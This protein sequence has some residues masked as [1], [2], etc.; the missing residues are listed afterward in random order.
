VVHALIIDM[1][2]NFIQLPRNLGISPQNSTFL[3]NKEKVIYIFDTPHLIKATRN[4]LLKYNF[5]INNK[6]AF[7][8]TLYNFINETACN[9]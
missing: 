6:I 9:G 4:N 8:I 1:D 2:S 7:W 5:E 3:V